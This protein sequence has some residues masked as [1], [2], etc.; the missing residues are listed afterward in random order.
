MK[1][2]IIRDNLKEA[3]G[4]VEKIENENINL[5]VLKNFL[6][7][8]ENNRLKI[9]ATNLE[10]AVS[11]VVGSKVIEEGKYTAPI[12]LF[13]NIINNIH[14]DRLNI[15]H[16]GT[17]IEIKTDNYEAALQ[18]ISADEFPPTPKIKNKDFFLEIQA[19]TLKDAIGQVL[20]S[21]QA[22]DLRPEL[23]SILFNF[24]VDAL[25]FAATDSFR[26]SEKI[27]TPEQFSAT[28]AE[29]FKVLVPLKTAEYVLRIFKDEETVKIFHDENQIL[30]TTERADIL[31]RLIDGNF[32]DYTALV[33]K[34]FNAEI[35]VKK[36]DFINSLK[37]VSVLSNKNNEIKFK[38]QPDKKVIEVMSASDTLGENTYMLSGKI[39]G[40]SQEIVF[41][42]R[43]V[44]DALKAIKTEEVFLGINKEGDPS[45]IKSAGDGSY[46]YILKPI[47]A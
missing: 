5:P 42:W 17:K 6:L 43:Y 34:K 11:C 23:N 16:K 9:T 22:N 35:V 21:S 27:L 30:F 26:L 2:I 31:S 12:K 14:N 7:S 45:E 25:R 3:V 46:F 36:E 47:A 4:V 13:S 37:L 20:V 38:I 29:G 44:A 24:S 15:E 40:E 10:V 33:P 39:K 41:N 1:F 28:H 18:G 8:A 19:A 32:P